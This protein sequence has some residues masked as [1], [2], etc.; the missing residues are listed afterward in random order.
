MTANDFLKWLLLLKQEGYNLN[1]IPL[2]VVEGNQGI[3]VIPKYV[4]LIENV[5][6]FNDEEDIT[7]Q[8]Q[9]DRALLIGPILEVDGH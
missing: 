7:L 5:S 4:T 8:T 1:D 3:S 2:L 9:F 6:K